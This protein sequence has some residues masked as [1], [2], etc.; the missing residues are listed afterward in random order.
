MMLTTR[1]L[2]HR[3]ANN[4]PQRS[5]LRLRRK[6][7]QRAWTDFLG[8]LEWRLFVTL[9]FDP[10][11]VFPI[12]QE[13]ASREAF[14]W[15]NETARIYRRPL[16]WVYAP[17]RGTSGQYHVHVLMIGTPRLVH[18]HVFLLQEAAGIWRARN[19]NID[20]RP[21]DDSYGV[22]FYSCKQ[23]AE[24]GELVWSDTLFKYRDAL[25][26]APTVNLFPDGYPDDGETTSL[27]SA[28]SP[29]P[30]DADVDDPGHAPATDETADRD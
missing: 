27:G 16:G 28:E 3:S 7:Q 11:R 29:G 18:G 21:V 13:L 4:W 23:A 25:Q 17:E 30:C 24:A 1:Y 6:E 15:C 22:T 14:W 26:A 10:K 5:K 12:G 9:T 2:L 20:V 19:G 8:R